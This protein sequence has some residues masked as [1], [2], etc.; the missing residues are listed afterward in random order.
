[1]IK[2][3]I[4]KFDIGEKVDAMTCDNGANFVNAAESLLEQGQIGDFVRCIC[5]SLQL[6]LKAGL[7]KP[8]KVHS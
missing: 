1:M 7:D 8:A 3:V 4:V 2:A 5:H 6:S